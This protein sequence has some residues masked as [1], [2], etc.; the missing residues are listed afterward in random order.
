M[1]P[2]SVFDPAS[3]SRP[4]AW[5]T[6]V[7]ANSKL[8]DYVA[9]PSD[10]PRAARIYTPKTKDVP[11]LQFLVDRAGNVIGVRARIPASAGRQ[12][13]YDGGGAAGTPGGGTTGTG[14][15]GTPTGAGTAGGTTG[16]VPGIGAGNGWTT[17]TLYLVPPGGRSATTPGTATRPGAPGTT[18]G[19][20]GT[21]GTVT[22][23]AGPGTTGPTAPGTAG[24][25]SVGITGPGTAAPG[26]TGT[27]PGTRTGWMPGTP[28][29]PGVPGTAWP[30][31][32][33][34]TGTAG[35]TYGLSSLST[36][37]RYNPQLGRLQKMGPYMLGMGQ[38]WGHKGPGIEVMTDRKGR[39]VALAG[40][41]PA[42]QTGNGWQRFYDQEPNR[43]SYD[44]TMGQFFWS[45]HVYF[46]D[47]AVIR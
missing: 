37:L 29:P 32:A 4:V 17:Q 5:S 16:A 30:N 11:S 15:T 44:P 3:L 19:T 34:V 46:V 25:G 27:A 22:G 26:R 41:F 28:P 40:A 39:V 33:S 12:P 43:P 14:A 1:L 36:L 13:W 7:Q 8:A 21:T 2:A 24:P 38:H 42:D 31:T 18:G 35:A 45:Q 20:T 23:P 9:Q 47:P 10:D 6:L